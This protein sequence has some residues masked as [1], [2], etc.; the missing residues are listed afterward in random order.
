MPVHRALLIDLEKT[1]AKIEK[2]EKVVTVAVDGNGVVIVTEPK[3]KRAKP[4]TKET[5]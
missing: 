3:V 4:G 5:R 2:T 1:V